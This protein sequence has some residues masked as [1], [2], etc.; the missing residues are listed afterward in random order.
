MDNI[1][2]L[3]LKDEETTES[4]TMMK[5]ED[6]E[7]DQ[8]VDSEAYKVKKTNVGEDGIE[9]A[10]EIEHFSHEHDL[11]LTYEV[12]NNEKCN[13][14]LRDIVPPFYS[15]AKCSFFLHKSCAELPRKKRH[16]LHLHPLTLS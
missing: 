10:I 11:K 2:L 13:G 5:N 8:S 16:P 14:C 9:I 15:C 6:T 3:E 1:N 12:Q 7:L 4:K